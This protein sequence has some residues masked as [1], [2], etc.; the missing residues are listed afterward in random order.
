MDAG[1]NREVLVDNSSIA[2]VLRLLVTISLVL[3]LM[4]IITSEA[5]L[6]STAVLPFVV[7]DLGRAWLFL[8]FVFRLI[9]FGHG[10]VE[11]SSAGYG[12]LS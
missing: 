2:L 7:T 3:R 10:L 6:G 12:L 8:G 1:A 4:F 5:S 11:L 9:G